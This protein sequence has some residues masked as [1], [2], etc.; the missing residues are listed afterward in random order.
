MFLRAS[1]W[2]I[3]SRKISLWLQNLAV[4][5]SVSL[6][7]TEETRYTQC[8]T[9]YHSQIG[10][11]LFQCKV[12]APPPCVETQ[13][14]HTSSSSSSSSSSLHTPF[15]SPLAETQYSSLSV[16]RGRFLI[17]PTRSDFSDIQRLLQAL[18]RNTTCFSRSPARLSESAAFCLWIIPIRVLNRSSINSMELTTTL[19][20]LLR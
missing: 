15:T 4:P 13:R 11:Q 16:W 10:H 7:G 14:V 12:W 1:V 5:P 3:A 18:E 20:N 6:T 9:A 8:E 17:L 19:I 2:S